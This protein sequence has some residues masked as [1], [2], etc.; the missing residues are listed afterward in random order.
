MRII[1]VTDTYTNYANGCGYFTYRLAQ[2]LKERGH[3][4]AIITPS[5]SIKN[6]IE[7]ESGVA[8]YGVSSL[9]A[10]FQEKFRF[11]P[12][13]LIKRKIRQ[14]VKNFE[15]DIIH[16]QNHYLIGREI[17]NIAFESGIP[18]IG[19]NHFMPENLLFYLHLPSKMEIFAKTFAWKH[20]SSLYKKLDF[21][22]APTKSAADILKKIGFTKEVLPISNGIDLEVFS[23][24]KKNNK[25]K[26]KYGIPLDKKI[27]LYVGRLDKD[28]E[29]ETVV[30]A[31]PFIKESGFHFVFVG[32][33]KERLALEKLAL[34]LGVLKFITF[35]GFI[36]DDE[37]PQ[38]YS[39]ADIFVM[40]GLVELQSIA[41]MEAM[42]SG[43]SVIA[44]DALALPELA[45]HNENGFLFPSRDSKNLA[46]Y[47]D[48]LL[49]NQSLR[50]KM[51][52]KSL[53]IIKK[54]DIE[55]VVNSFEDIY[56]KAVQLPRTYLKPRLAY[57][58]ALYGTVLAILGVFVMT[59]PWGTLRKQNTTISKINEKEI[60]QTNYKTIKTNVA[61]FKTYLH[62]KLQKINTE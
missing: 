54:H 60:A 26:I 19:T 51:G 53:E 52:E 17:A 41:T 43:L 48:T 22:T 56:I 61:V 31:I 25:I 40:A 21:V 16:L 34:E 35:T 45:H 39:S 2:K 28:K 55:M 57:K 9:P 62:N 59:M 7:D 24:S 15:P 50:K 3:K 37:L 27:V 38:I 29:L 8:R 49:S 46:M 42:A 18:I 44:A 20:F 47:L 6:S 5:R 11:S 23:P 13:F 30:R 33:G 10:F 12:R 14:I 1:L 32:I 58:L 4:V 36:P